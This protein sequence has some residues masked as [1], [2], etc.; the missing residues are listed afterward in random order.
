[1]MG[2]SRP[3]A[4][5]PGVLYGVYLAEVVAVTGDP[6]NL[7]RLQIRLLGFDGVGDQ[8]APMW[9]RVA[10]PFA[11]ANRGAFFIPNK[12]D[13]VAVQ[14]V[15]GD[16]RQPLVIGGLW[17]GNQAPPE[18]IGG[19]E[20]DR[21]TFV[22]KN[23]TRVAIVEESQGQE[24]IHLATPNQMNSAV[25]TADSGGKIELK[26]SMGTIKIETSGITIQSSAKVTI[27][28][29]QVEVKAGYVDVNSAFTNFSGVVKCSTL[30]AT[31][32]VGS[33]YT[34]GAGNV[35]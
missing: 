28:A 20:I 9:A 6:D 30:M 8:D 31:T 5:R 19:D 7:G 13:E 14:F 26:T 2:E 11:G 22:G 4:P 23:G 24:Q 25:I 33:V 34:P 1:M 15:N 35:W 10:V 12:G 18:T 27:Q 17:N 16:P 21:W 32:V 29:S 3:G